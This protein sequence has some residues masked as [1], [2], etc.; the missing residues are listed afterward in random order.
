M[1][2]H[3]K[4]GIFTAITNAI[5]GNTRPTKASCALMM[6]FSGFDGGGSHHVEWCSEINQMSKPSG[7][8]IHQPLVAWIQ[9][10]K[11]LY[12]TVML[13]YNDDWYHWVR[14]DDPWY[15]ETIRSLW[16]MTN[17]QYC[18]FA[19]CIWHCT[20]MD[21]LLAVLGM[22]FKW[23]ILKISNVERLFHRSIAPDHWQQLEMTG[24]KYISLVIG[25]PI[26][27]GKQAFATTPPS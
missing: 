15:F 4:I 23:S 16:Q 6:A 11:I 21:G 5:F 20:F 14:W 25:T 7:S 10:P 8:S 24:K 17:L 1:Q 19:A 13:L 22:Q 9:L 26:H 2:I 3:W 27:W 12:S 18:R